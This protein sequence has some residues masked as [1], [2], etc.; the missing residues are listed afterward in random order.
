MTEN[1]S[2]KSEKKQEFPR[3]AKEM[4]KIIKVGDRENCLIET[5][6]REFVALRALLA[7]MEGDLQGAETYAEIVGTLNRA[8]IEFTKSS[9]KN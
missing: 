7:T 3:K 8:V 2:D 5:V 1:K 6:Q 4:L 9:Q